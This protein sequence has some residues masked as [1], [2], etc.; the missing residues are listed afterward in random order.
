MKYVRNAMTKLVGNAYSYYQHKLKYLLQDK[1]PLEFCL[2]SNP[3]TPKQLKPKKVKPPKQQKPKKVKPPKPVVDVTVKFSKLY[4][5]HFKISS[6]RNFTQYAREKYF[7]D[8]HGY[9]SWEQE[10]E[11]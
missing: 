10:P 11:Q 6:T 4:R 2:P 8:T 5:E 7:Y 1:E 3:A 9:P